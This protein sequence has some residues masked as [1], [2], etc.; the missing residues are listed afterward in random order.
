MRANSWAWS[1]TGRFYNADAQMYDYVV[2][3][4]LIVGLTED[5]F[6]SLSD[7]MIEKYTRMFRRCYSLLEDEDGKRY[8]VRM[9]PKQ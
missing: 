1:S 4:F 9:K 3:T 8:F 2:G 7:E 5:D 6:G